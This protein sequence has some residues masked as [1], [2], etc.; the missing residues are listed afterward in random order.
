MLRV[1]SLNNEFNDFCK[2]IKD[3]IEVRS[4]LAIYEFIV[5]SKVCPDTSNQDWFNTL[6]YMHTKGWLY[7]VN[8]KG[9]IAV[10]IGAYR[11]KNLD[12]LD[13]LPEIENGEILYVPFCASI[14]DD[15]TILKKMLDSYSERNP[16]VKEVI[17]KKF[18]DG[19]KLKRFEI[20]KGA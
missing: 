12:N 1:G 9:K 5:K 16:D 8:D 13:I 4:F 19:E 18:K 20:N 11:V 14:S 6:C 3:F 15:N 2:K 7:V 17:F 10:V